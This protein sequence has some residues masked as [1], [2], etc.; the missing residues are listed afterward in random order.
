MSKRSNRVASNDFLLCSASDQPHGGHPRLRA[1]PRRLRLWGRRRGCSRRCWRPRWPFATG[2]A[3][4]RSTGSA[5]RRRRLSAGHLLPSTAP[6]RPRL[7]GAT[8]LPAGESLWDQD[9]QGLFAPLRGDHRAREVSSSCEQ[10]IG[11]GKML[12]DVVDHPLV[13]RVLPILGSLF[14]L[15]VSNSYNTVEP[16]SAVTSL[17]W[18]VY[19]S[20]VDTRIYLSVLDA[21]FVG[22]KLF[23]LC[24]KF[25]L[26]MKMFSSCLSY[27]DSSLSRVTSIFLCC[28]LF[29]DLVSH[30]SLGNR[31]G[32]KVMH[33]SR[34]SFLPSREII[35]TMVNSMSYQRYFYNQ[36]PVFDGRK[37]MY[38]REPLVVGRDKVRVFLSL[39]HAWTML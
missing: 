8:D 6:T 25:S 35:E 20:H 26:P 11:K 28:K 19:F 2:H 12:W 17:I 15:S 23:A 37:N 3:C 24:R 39:F 9:A 38:T 33:G 34:F 14:E 10:V 30:A 16:V 31:L 5:R 27:D 22:L 7:R 1:S 4:A 32:D 29:I 21:L 13:M 18:S 36:K